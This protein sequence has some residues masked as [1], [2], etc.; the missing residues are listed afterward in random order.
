MK[1][2]NLLKQLLISSSILAVLFTD[3]LSAQGQTQKTTSQASVVSQ[4]QVSK[5]DLQRFARAIQKLQVIQRN[6]QMEIARVIQREGLSLGRFKQIYQVQRN[7]Q[8]RRTVV[9]TQQER[10]RFELAIA[11]IGKIQNQTQSVMLKAIQDSGLEVK[12][13]NQIFAAV[14]RNPVLQQ[15]VQQILRS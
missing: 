9:V 13:F 1:K 8:A 11:K 6:S 4:A 5:A 14:Q 3:S 7:P 10:Q 15:R 12:L 2:N